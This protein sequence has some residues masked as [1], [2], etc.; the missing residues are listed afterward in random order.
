MDSIGFYFNTL[1]EVVF[2]P[3]ISAPIYFRLRRSQ[4][5][6]ST[7]CPRSSPSGSLYQLSV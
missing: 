7:R 6:P 2:P 4:H 1:F 3:H 5:F